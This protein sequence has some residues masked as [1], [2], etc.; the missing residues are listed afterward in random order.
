M[1]RSTTLL[2]LGVSSPLQQQHSLRTGAFT[3]LVT[4]KRHGVG[5]FA[6]QTHNKMLAGNGHQDMLRQHTRDACTC[7]HTAVARPDTERLLQRRRRKITSP[8]YRICSASRVSTRIFDIGQGKPGLAGF[9]CG[10]CTVVRGGAF[11]PIT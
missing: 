8:G 3:V 10:C 1:I 2:M 6:G 9:S 11:L 7:M 4:P 5:F